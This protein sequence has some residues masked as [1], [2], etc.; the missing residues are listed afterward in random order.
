MSTG[1]E[2]DVI[3]RPLVI[4]PLTYWSDLKQRTGG[5]EPTLDSLV[6]WANR[7][8]SYSVSITKYLISL[9]FD[10]ANA[11]RIPA[12]AQEASGAADFAGRGDGPHDYCAACV[13]ERGCGRMDA[14]AAPRALQS[15]GGGHVTAY[16]QCGYGH[17]WSC[18]FAEPG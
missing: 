15:H 3:L 14:I 5:S 18:N 10:P 12:C 16:Y 6:R 1:R 7:G 17:A 9:D 11:A 8:A 13:H 2:P 4:A